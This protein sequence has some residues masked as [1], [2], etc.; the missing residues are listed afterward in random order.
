M[1]HQRMRQTDTCEDRLHQYWTVIKRET[2]SAVFKPSHPDISDT[3]P[4]QKKHQTFLIFHGLQMSKSDW[5]VHSWNKRKHCSLVKLLN[6]LTTLSVM[7]RT[8]VIIKASLK[9]FVC[10]WNKI[11]KMINVFTWCCG[12]WQD[13]V[14]IRSFLCSLLEISEIEDA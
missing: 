14:H 10:L 6:P 3:T 4:L 13:C 8:T 5:L 2:F 1:K 9:F 12:H 11:K 7:V